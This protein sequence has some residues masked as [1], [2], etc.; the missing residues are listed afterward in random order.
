MSKKKLNDIEIRAKE[1]YDQRRAIIF[2]EAALGELMDR[3]DIGE[4]KEIY[5]TYE[6]VLIEL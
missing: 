2:F 3:F 4:V 1:L 5:R 6:D